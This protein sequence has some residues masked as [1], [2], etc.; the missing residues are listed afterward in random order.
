MLHL[1]LQYY[2]NCIILRPYK[3][4]DQKFVHQVKESTEN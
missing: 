3:L 2:S 1:V 4:G